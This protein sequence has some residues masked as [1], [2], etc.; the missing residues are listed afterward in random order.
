MTIHLKGAANAQ[1]KKKIVTSTEKIGFLKGYNYIKKGAISTQ[2]EK[3]YVLTQAYPWYL[4]LKVCRH[5]N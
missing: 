3:F 2:K 1:W 5:L 4:L